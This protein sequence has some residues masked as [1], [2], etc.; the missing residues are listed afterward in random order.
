MKW[1]SYSI[2]I[3]AVLNISICAFAKG[4]KYLDATNTPL[5]F[6]EAMSYADHKESRYIEV[7]VERIN[8]DQMKRLLGNDT[9]KYRPY[10]VAIT[11]NSRF[12][13]YLNQVVVRDSAG[14]AHPY[15]DLSDVVEAIDPGGRG[16]KDDMR[17]AALRGNILSKALPFTVITPGDT[18]QGI[19]FVKDKNLSDGSELYL[20][21]QNLKRV[22]FLEFVMPIKK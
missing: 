8:K 15:V 14:Q 5:S 12:R 3:F 20:Q 19:V 21:I 9:G 13:I 11:N 1:F 10:E 4:D 16:N 7:G 17:D 22:A 6:R 2:A 18:I